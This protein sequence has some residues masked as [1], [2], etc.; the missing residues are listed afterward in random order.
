MAAK[1]AGS[2]VVSNRMATWRDT[3]SGQVVCA[4]DGRTV[5]WSPRRP[6]CL[7]SRNEYGDHTLRCRDCPG[8][9]EFERRRLAGRLVE[10]YRD[11]SGELFIAYIRAPT[12]EHSG[13]RHNLSRRR[14]VRLESG[15]FRLGPDRFAVLCREREDLERAC[16]SLHRPFTPSRVRLKRGRVAFSKLTSGLRVARA[17]FG[18]QVKRWY[19]KGLPPAEKE[20]NEIVRLPYQRGYDPRRSPRAHSRNNQDL[21]PPGFWTEHEHD[22]R[23]VDRMLAHARDPESVSAVMA[24]VMPLARG[25]AFNRS[26]EA[27]PDRPIPSRE[28]M[29]SWYREHARKANDAA[30]AASTNLSSPTASVG[31][32]SSSVHSTSNETRQLLSDQD[33]ARAGPTELNALRERNQS[34]RDARQGARAETV[35]RIQRETQEIIARMAAK[36]AKR[37]KGE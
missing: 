27:A 15:L 35:L 9:R 32:Y 12:S 36:Q 24:V 33:L 16:R 20:R 31:R 5:C 11:C 7:R 4:V 28:A 26:G 10:K 21:F 6:G 22:K 14:G 34:E 19:A 8:C 13:L 1:A 23:I 18:A 25:L 3:A 30:G 29:Q 2:H 17:A 37:E